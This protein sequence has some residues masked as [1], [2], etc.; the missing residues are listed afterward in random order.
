M[1]KLTLF[2][3]LFAPLVFSTANADLYAELGFEGGGDEIIG[4]NTGDEINAGG[5]IKLSLG[6]QNPVNETN[7]SAIRLSVGY[8]FDSIDAAN[9]D[10]DFETLT[11]DAMYIMN[12]GPH[13]IGVGATMHMSPEYKDRIA[14]FAPLTLEFDDAVGFVLQYGYH[15]TPGFEIGA[16]L[17]DI[18]YEVGATTVDAGSFGIYLSNGF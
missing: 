10:A 15:I 16:R 17:S 4:T 8:L 14:G 2:L 9:G 6:I 3:T 12:S 11:F 13:S 1:K 18:D 7:T 5:G